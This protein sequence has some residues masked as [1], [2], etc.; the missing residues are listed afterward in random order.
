MA[1]GIGKVSESFSTA[2]LL[3]EGRF[4]YIESSCSKLANFRMI[5]K[6]EY[7]LT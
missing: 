1:F 6:H 3:V 2:Y 7:L 5:L 4:S